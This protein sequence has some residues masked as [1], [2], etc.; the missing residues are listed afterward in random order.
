MAK[1]HSTLIP[2]VGYARRSTDMQERSIPDQQ[3]YIIKWAEEHGYRIIRWYIDDAISGTS[4]KGRNAFE[5]MIAAAEN[6]RDFDVVLCY[7]ISRF[8]RGGTN[9][10]GYYLHRLRL[11]GVDALFAA[12]GIPEG[13]EGELIQGVKSWQA[14]Q[15]SVKLAKDSIRGQISN[16]RQRKSA[17]GGP[18]P[19]GYDK[20]HLTADGKLLRTLRWATDGSKQEFDPD[21]KLVRVIASDIYVAKSKGDIV[22][23]VPSTPDR[24]AAIRR[25]FDLCVSGYGFR[26]TAEVLNNDGVP[27]MLGAKWNSS[28]I[29]QLLRSPVYC[30]SLVYNKRSSGS[31]FGMDAEG[32]LRP[33]KGGG[34]ACVL[35]PTS[36][37]MIEE[38]VHEPLVSRETFEAA[39]RAIAKRRDAGGKA[40]PVQRTLCSTLLVCKRCG[41]SFTTVR[42]R[43]R[44]PK[45]GPPYRHYT[46]SGYHRYGKAVC[47]LVRI[48]GQAL[49]EFVLGTIKRIL[50]ADHSTTKQAIDAFVKAV[51]APVKPA[52][53]ASDARRELE[54]LDRRIKTTVGMLADLTFEGLDDLQRVLADLKAKRDALVARMD[55]GPRRAAPALSERQLRT[56]AR[57]QFDRL[58]D[59]TQ[60]ETVDLKDRQLVEAFVQ[61]IEVFPDD[62]SGVI[63]M[64]A[65]LKSALECSTRVNGGDDPQTDESARSPS[66][67][68]QRESILAGAVLGLGGPGRKISGIM[69]CTVI[70]PDD[71]AD[72]ILNRDKHP[73]WQGDRT[74]MVYAFPSNE[75]LWQ[76]YG[77]VRADAL[78]NERGLAEATEFYRR[79]RDEMDEGAVVAWPE[80]FN[81]DE[82][83]AVQHA[84]NLRLQNEAAFFAEYQNEPLP[85]QTA[86]DDL[87]T[88]DQIAGKTHGLERGLIPLGCNHLTAFIDVQQKLLF[89]VVCAWEDDFTGYVVDYRTYP[90]QRR[91][92]FTL[93]DATRTLAVAAKGTGLEGAIYAGLESLTGELLGRHWRRDD[94]AELRIDRCLIDANWGSSTDVVYQF[95]RQSPHAGIVL[96]SHGR[97]VGASSRPFSEYARKPGERVGLNW[98]ITSS[99]GKRAVRHALFDTNYWKSFVQARLVVAQGDPGCLSL[100]GS[101]PDVHRLLADH[102]TAEYR[103][104]TEGRGRTVDEWKSRPEQPDNHWLDGVVGCAVAASIQGCI[105]FGTDERDRKV[106]PRVHLSAL[107]R[108]RR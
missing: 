25:I 95:C 91:S 22:R 78:R 48:P 20:Q 54:Q 28:N 29:A 59:L 57:E 85:E 21:G 64:H 39:Q 7:D 72:R 51:L 68:A 65:D 70:R 99:V 96:P 107:Q 88:A 46:C 53:Q 23:Y 66:Q 40:R 67:C 79:H 102:L 62:N 17:P 12:D 3:A 61:R 15:Y 5:Q 90:D 16:I 31:L 26:Y 2:A 32:K 41:N 101:N 93:R 94:G 47:G 19:Y 44:D 86:D 76:Q 9:E 4:A 55:S 35:N 103:V 33:K 6:G 36:D 8:S 82:L 75:K 63:Y 18:P 58:D 24:V 1:R 34:K 43:R 60:R 69:P 83:S 49:D 87:L 80:R 30:G 74:K 45:L 52:K 42:D 106:R 84:M 13:D 100:F 97:F 14:R 56:W 108:S 11:A 71:M 104:K 37:W 89:Y 38:N 77:R 92:Y 73:Q 10:T 50:I 98:R 27:T 105:L 81:P